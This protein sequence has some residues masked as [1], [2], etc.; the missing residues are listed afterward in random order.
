[1]TML[2]DLPPSS[3][4]TPARLRAACSMMSAPTPSDPVNDTRSTSGCEDNCRPTSAPPM[5][6]FMTPGG[7]PDSWMR[8]P[9]NRV[10]SGVRGDGSS[11]TVHP[12]ASAA[13]NLKIA[14]LSG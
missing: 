8:S 12:A 1:M 2:G 6:T 11:T 7:S 10:V 9:S 4:V 3:S 13:P 5:M 14:R